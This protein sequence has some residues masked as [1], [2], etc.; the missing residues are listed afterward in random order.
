MDQSDIFSRIYSFGVSP[1]IGQTSTSMRSTLLD[2]ENQLLMDVKGRYPSIKCLYPLVLQIIKDNDISSFRK[3]LIEYRGYLPL[4][5]ERLAYQVHNPDMLTILLPLIKDQDIK[6][7]I[8]KRIRILT[9][10]TE[11]ISKEEINEYV[12][13]ILFEGRYDLLGDKKYS[14]Q[15]WVIPS[16]KAGIFSQV[17]S[18]A[19]RWISSVGLS[20]YTGKSLNPAFLSD[21]EIEYQLPISI[22]DVPAMTKQSHIPSIAYNN[23]G[24]LFKIYEQSPDHRL[25]VLSKALQEGYIEILDCFL[26]KANYIGAL[27]HI[28]HIII[29]PDTTVRYLYRYGYHPEWYLYLID[30]QKYHERP[31]SSFITKLMASIISYDNLTLYNR[32]VYTRSSI[33]ITL[34]PQLEAY[35]KKVLPSDRWPDYIR[36]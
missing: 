35:I 24:I 16:M 11:G 29:L 18:D 12:W 13:S 8:M 6:K 17:S 32:I 23:L 36:I 20:A 1:Q 3:L 26:T 21:D 25:K 31:P 9:L 7:N 2:V 22:L 30:N 34:R 33:M 4:N 19:Q 27:A 5:I 14:F 15:D 28:Q 10:G